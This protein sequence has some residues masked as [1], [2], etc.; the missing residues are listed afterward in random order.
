MASATLQ[1]IEMGI[2]RLSRDEQ[3]WLIEQLAHRLRANPLV[4]AMDKQLADMAA[5]PDVQRELR[6]IDREFRGT[7]MDGLENM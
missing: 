4:G 1:K 6:A 5:D 2:G 7:E 3:L